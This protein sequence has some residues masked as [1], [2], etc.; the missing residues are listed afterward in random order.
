MKKFEIINGKW[1]K[2]DSYHS[3]HI[4]ICKID[5]ISQITYREEDRNANYIDIYNH[6]GRIIIS[7]N[8]SEQELSKSDFIFLKNLLC[9]K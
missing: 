3:S 1:I 5:S 2:V 8:E 6:G 4:D 9:N 7:Y